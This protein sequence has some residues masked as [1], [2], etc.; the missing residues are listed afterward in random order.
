MVSSPAAR[1]RL[2]ATPA[3][4]KPAVWRRDGL[5]SHPQSRPRVVRGRQPLGA[6]LFDRKRKAICFSGLFTGVMVPDEET[7]PPTFGLGPIYVLDPI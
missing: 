7:K 1:V 4:R 3:A 2:H 5:R 6:L